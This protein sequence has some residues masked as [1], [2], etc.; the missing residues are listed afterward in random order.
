MLAFG[1]DELEPCPDAYPGYVVHCMRCGEQHSLECGTDKNTGEP[2][3]DL[4][5]YRCGDEEYL[6]AIG[7]KVVVSILTKRSQDASM[8]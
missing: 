3:S 7:G 4:M 5:F 2:T 6:G 8:G 1:N